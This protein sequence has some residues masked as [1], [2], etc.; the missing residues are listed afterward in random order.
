VFH[1]A[2]GDGK[3]VKIRVYTLTF[4]DFRVKREGI[5]EGLCGKLNKTTLVL[6]GQTPSF[7]RD[8][9]VASGSPPLTPFYCKLQIAN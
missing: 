5:E 9:A 7:D 8:V 6:L 4:G 3:L 1:L 2:T